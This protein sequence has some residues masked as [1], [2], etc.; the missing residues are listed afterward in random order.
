MSTAD[1]ITREELAAA[2][3]R[4]GLSSLADYLFDDIVRDREPEYERGHF[5]EDALGRVFF[6][7]LGDGKGWSSA[8]EGTPYPGDYP[9]RPL[10]RL[11]PEPAV[12]QVGCEQI[13]GI[14]TEYVDA[15]LARDAAQRICELLNER[16]P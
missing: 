16:C 5:Y 14:I 13:A 8:P 1:T 2:L 11:V 9:R 10:R 4:R 7:L 6:R 15:P 12:N 3:K